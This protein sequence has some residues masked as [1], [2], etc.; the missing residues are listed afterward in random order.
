MNCDV[1]SIMRARCFGWHQIILEDTPKLDPFQIPPSNVQ[2]WR[3]E[4][5]FLQGESCRG[6]GGSQQIIRLQCRSNPIE[7][8]VRKYVAFIMQKHCCYCWCNLKI[9]YLSTLTSVLLIIDNCYL[10]VWYAFSNSFFTIGSMPMFQTPTM[11]S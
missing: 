9:L 1:I 2:G 3:V 6:G 7:K 10:V 4:T 8:Q 11:Y 5:D